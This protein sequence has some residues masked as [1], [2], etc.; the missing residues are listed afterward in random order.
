[1]LKIN[2]SNF[3]DEKFREYISSTFDTDKTGYLTS[4]ELKRVLEIDLANNKEIINLRGIEHFQKLRYLRCHGTGI[5]ELDVSKNTTLRELVCYDTGLTNLYL[6]NNAALRYLDCH[7]TKITELNVSN[8]L[9][10]EYVNCYGTEITKINV[11]ID[12]CLE[13]YS[14]TDIILIKNND[15]IQ[16]KVNQAKE[17]LINKQKGRDYYTQ[18]FIDVSKYLYDMGGVDASDEWSQGYDT[19]IDNMYDK[20]ESFSYENYKMNIELYEEV[21][22]D[23]GN[24]GEE[25]I[26]KVDIVSKM[27]I[28]A[29]REGIKDILEILNDSDVTI[30]LDEDSQEFG[31]GYRE[32]LDE[33]KSFLMEGLQDSSIKDKIKQAKE[34]FKNKQ[35]DAKEAKPKEWER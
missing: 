28:P 34:M 30:S 27:K 3:P 2:E 32:V 12:S 5:T 35:K 26:E 29:Y 22:D 10:L 21:M 18:S 23:Y 17:N 4:N 33:T 19:A 11:S 20:I 16:D 8:N 7:N 13:V 24:N 14:H 25:S 31:K 1:M 15:S 9:K 6:K